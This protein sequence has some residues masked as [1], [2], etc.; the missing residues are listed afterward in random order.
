MATE[1]ALYAQMAD[2]FPRT[3]R[4]SP[5][6]SRSYAPCIARFADSRTT[7]APLLMLYGADDQLIRPERCAQ[8]ADDLRSG[9]SLW[10]SSPIPERCISGMAEC[11]DG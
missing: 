3:G 1:Y 7:G 2:A 10:R 11:H 4:A 9:G 8:V 5:A 6:T